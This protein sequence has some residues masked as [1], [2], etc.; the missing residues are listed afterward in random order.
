MRGSTPTSGDLFIPKRG[1]LARGVG[2]LVPPSR[3]PKNGKRTV[4]V[5]DLDARRMEESRERQEERKE[6][7]RSTIVNRTFE[8]YFQPIVDLRSQQPVGAEALS[9]FAHLPVRSPDAWFAEAASVGLGVELEL[10]ALEM[11][12]GQLRHLPANLYLS[13]NASVPTLMSE[14][15]QA[16]I[17]G[18]P[19][20]RIVIELTEHA[21][22]ADYDKLDQS[23]K[24]I[25]SR[26]TRLAVDDAGSGYS[27]LQHILN[28]Q[29]DVI[30]L[31]I[32][33]T[34]GIDRDPA[35]LALG[36][37]LLKFGFDAYRASIVAEGIE[38][39]GEYETLRSLGCPAGQGFYLGR[40]SRLALQQLA[41]I[42]PM[43]LL[44]VPGR[45]VR[46]G[47]PRNGSGSTDTTNQSVDE[48]PSGTTDGTAATAAPVRT[49]TLTIEPD[50][51]GHVEGDAPEVDA[52]GH[53]EEPESRLL[54]R[55]A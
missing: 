34:R 46:S 45:A 18:V 12:I 3:R 50:D 29:P 33:L 9:R 1:K 19:A 49:R 48:S 26:G 15:F 6:L 35:R 27:S 44:S 37:A 13:V 25:R 14:E 22:V 16:I 10:A 36:R 53:A 23:I 54:Y 39:V 28:L 38:T 31:D 21:E 41:P 7:I 11:A 40:P 32:G 8:T 30:K 43:P 55:R 51:T 47:T 2:M 5:R 42:A 20:E 52:E 17:G 24:G 4:D